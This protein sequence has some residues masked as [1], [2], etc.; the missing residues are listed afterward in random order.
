MTAVADKVTWRAGAG[1][2]VFVCFLIASIEGYDIQ[3]F[4]IAAPKLVRELGLDPAQQGWAAS[5]ATI[6][7][8]L[9]ALIGGW[10]SD[11]LGRK[12]VLV[13]ALAAF[14]LFSLATAASTSYEMLLLAR[15]ATGLGF[16]G[17]MPN[18][19]TLAAEISP[20]G[21]RGA[22]ITAIFCGMPAGGIVAALIARLAGPQLDWRMIFLAGGLA[23]LVLVPVALML[24]PET[25]PAPEPTADRNLL[26]AL[27][28]E[29]RAAATLLL[30]AVFAPTVTILYLSLNW[31]PTLVVD[32]GLA[33]SEGFAAAMAFNTGAVIGTLALGAVSDRLGWRWPLTLAYL[34]L[35]AAMG[36]LA[37]AVHAGP[38]FALSALAGFMVVGAQFALY[39]LP[40][41]LYPPQ[42]RAAGAGAAIGI[43]R[44]GSIAGPLIAGGLRSAG[45]TPG[46]VFLAMTPVALIAAVC[47]MMLGRV[48]RAE[49][50]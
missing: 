23:P 33:A 35:A 49:A 41:Q 18:L 21:R 15:F 3:S 26:R 14:G 40:P 13:A 45:A 47:L 38:I 25:R 48:A 9:G 46:Q 22:T 24:L 44:L 50:E 29:G 34:V 5:A 19:A 8:V 4:G 39:A 6:G 42:W 32:K 17:A 7:L 31:L 43:G 28:G 16:G 27:M 37:L 2:V 12:P 10:L 1:L 30:W 11:R 20:P 36:G